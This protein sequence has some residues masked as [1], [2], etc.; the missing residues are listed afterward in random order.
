MANQD[1]KASLGTLAAVAAVS[2]VAGVA[3][4]GFL[5]TGA[6]KEDWTACF[7]ARTVIELEADA[8]GLRFYPA[9]ADGK[10]SAIA[11]P[12]S[13]E[14]GT[15]V[16]D[17]KGNARF[18]QFIAIRSGR[19]EMAHL[20]E[21]RARTAVLNAKRGDLAPWALDVENGMLAKLLAVSG[22]QGIALRE[23]QT[24]TG[25]GTFELV[26]ISISGGK[27]KQ[28]GKPSDVMVGSFPCPTV[29][30]GAKENYLNLGL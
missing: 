11:A 14:G 26:P 15:H 6:G 8:W 28:V 1:R 24:T 10:N 29:C 2:A 30:P 13:A 25:L 4:Y 22:A 5:Q 17:N 16:P 18:Y 12:V 19:T 21:A 9:Q 7:D 20:D 27:A 23:R 3:I